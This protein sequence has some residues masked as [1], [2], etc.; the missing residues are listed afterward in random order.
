LLDRAVR[1]PDVVVGAGVGENHDR[2][3]THEQ[4]GKQSDAGISHDLFQID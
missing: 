1:F 3:G 2:R 4:N